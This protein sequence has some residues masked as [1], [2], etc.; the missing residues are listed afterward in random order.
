M[1]MPF[2]RL[3]NPDDF[4]VKPLNHLAPGPSHGFGP[5]EYPWV[6]DD[7]QE[8]DETG[9]GKSYQRIAAQLRI[10]P[11]PRP[12][13]FGRFVLGLS[14]STAPSDGAFPSLK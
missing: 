3:R 7:P 13:V 12:L 4:T 10:E 9:P 5:L 11:G 6:C 8:P 2:R 14:E 1:A